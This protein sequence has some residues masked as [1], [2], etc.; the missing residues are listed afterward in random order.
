MQYVF[1]SLIDLKQQHENKRRKVCSYTYH[2][3][4]I[5]THK[6]ILYKITVGE[7]CIGLKGEKR[8]DVY[9]MHHMFRVLPYNQ[10]R[11]SG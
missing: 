4:N 2:L 9:R 3:F 7:I 8:T 10:L 1:R 5:K 6:T 11:E